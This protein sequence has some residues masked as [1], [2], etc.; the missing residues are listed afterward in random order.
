MRRHGQLLRPL[1]PARGENGDDPLVIAERLRSRVNEL[2][3]SADT[4]GV[5]EGTNEPM[6]VSIGVASSPTDGA[7]LADLLMAADSALYEAKA[8]GRNRVV[9]AGRGTG[10]VFDRVAHG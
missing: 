9:L 7:E 1:D 3:I 6:S 5:P 4:E 10:E 2:R 8:S